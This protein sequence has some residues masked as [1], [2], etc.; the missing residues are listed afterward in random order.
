[1][2]RSY[3]FFLMIGILFLY[4]S[5]KNDATE[6][7]QQQATP[8]PVIE[9]P[10]KSLSS[11][12]IYPAT[13]EGINS[14]DIRAKV[15][16]YI[17]HVLVDEGQKVKKGQVLFRLETASLSQ[18][19]EAA[20][21]N[22]NAAQVE[23]DKLIPLVEKNII[24][25]VQLE[26]AKARLAQAK[27]AFKSISANI[28]YAN[29]RSLVD[30]YVGAIPFREGALVSPADPTPLTT[31]AMTDEVFVYFS[32]NEKDYIDFLENTEGAT[33][34][35]KVNNFPEIELQLSNGTIYSEKG[36]I[37]T[38]TGQINR[39]TG[40]V[41]FRARF[42][43][44]TGLLASGSSGSIRIPQEFDNAVVI[45][46]VSTFERQGKVYAYKVQDDN[47]VVS[48]PIEVITRTEN[49]II[50]ESGVEKGD[51]IVAKGVAKLRN[52][53]PIL[54]QEADFENISSG[55]QPSFQ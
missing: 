14:S 29:I 41:N 18:D 17:T 39:S 52:N 15:T 13:I 55:L 33:R 12:T 16:G 44:P 20:Q 49:L 25:A 54:P 43:N 47:T 1:M 48:V 5:C 42:D 34:S 31:V 8:V 37:E 36:K 9:V 22:V 45:P 3:S 26:T 28:D 21:A 23:V 27:S 2:K 19:A 6:Q 51:R 32:L 11:Y 53:M 30:G 10:Q 38:V 50:V 35:E 46:E 7:Q 4:S 24:S 40:T